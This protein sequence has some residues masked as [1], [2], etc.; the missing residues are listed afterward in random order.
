MGFGIASGSVLGRAWISAAPHLIP[1]FFYT[2]HHRWFFFG[3]GG[4]K[5]LTDGYLRFIVTWSLCFCVFAGGLVLERR[6]EVSVC[7]YCITALLY[8]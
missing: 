3:G 5:D 4:T 8:Y 1:V 2:H 6:R 7:F